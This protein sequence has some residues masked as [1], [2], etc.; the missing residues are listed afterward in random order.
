MT[1]SLSAKKIEKGLEDLTEKMSQF[2]WKM[3]ETIPPLVC[4]QIS[5]TLFSKD[6]HEKELNPEWNDELED[7]RL[8]YYRPILFFSYEGKVCQKGWVGNTPV[9]AKETDGKDHQNYHKSYKKPCLKI[10]QITS[11]HSSNEQASLDTV[12]FVELAPQQT[13]V[14]AIVDQA[15]PDVCP[16][17]YHFGLRKYD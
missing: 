5:D 14:N 1:V 8:V 2:S 4:E 10:K 13:P 7:Y 15:S 12:G 11:T 9:D 6:W 17:S 16:A 3:L